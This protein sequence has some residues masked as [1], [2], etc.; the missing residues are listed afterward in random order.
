[1]SAC[2]LFKSERSIDFDD[3]FVVDQKVV[4]VIAVRHLMFDLVKV[5]F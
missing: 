5:L 2:A 4:P 1:M 3:D